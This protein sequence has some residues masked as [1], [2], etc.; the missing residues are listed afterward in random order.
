MRVALLWDSGAKKPS[1]CV[2]VVVARDTPERLHG[3]NEGEGGGGLQGHLYARFPSHT[4]LNA[5]RCTGQLGHV[6]LTGQGI[7]TGN[8]QVL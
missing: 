5:E 2:L 4:C 3:K 6:L 8:T 1:T 7:L